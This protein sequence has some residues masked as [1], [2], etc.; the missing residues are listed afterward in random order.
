MSAMATYANEIKRVR[1][2][3]IDTADIAR[4]TGAAKQT[5]TSWLRATRRPRAD[6]RDRLLELVA[7]VDRLSDV[8]DDD[9]IALW[10]QKPLV[11]LD[12]D[13]PLDAIAGGAYRRVSRLVAELENDSFA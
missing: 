6:H 10:L 13:R 5:V 2:L 8:M 12:D 7:I 1:A 4:A 3:G 11:A 9:Q